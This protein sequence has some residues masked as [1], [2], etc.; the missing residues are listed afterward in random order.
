MLDVAFRY[1]SVYV[2]AFGRWTHRWVDL[3]FLT[4]VVVC[5]SVML[6]HV[7]PGYL[8][9]G[10]TV[11]VS[12]WQMLVVDVLFHLT[13]FLWVV[14]KYRDYYRQ[15][16]WG[17]GV[18]WAVLLILAYVMWGRAEATYGMDVRVGLLGILMGGL[19]YGALT[20]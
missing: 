2:V 8:Q 10:E 6:F 11:K 1:L 15:N 20:V 7:H 18:A 17:A 19:L 4:S 13:P 5:E 3:M 12:G 16:T 14:W 9:I